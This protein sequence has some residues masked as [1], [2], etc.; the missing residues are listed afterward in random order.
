M[1]PIITVMKGSTAVVITLRVSLAIVATM[2]GS[3]CL[4]TSFSNAY[5]V[6]DLETA[7]TFAPGNGRLLA[8]AAHHTLS[9]DP[10][11]SDAQ[12]K[13]GAD[14][15]RALLTDATAAPAVATLGLLEQ[16]HGSGVAA[17]RYFAYGEWLSR[18]D[19]STQFWLIE[20]AVERGDVN[21]ALH[22]YD[23]VLRS[24]NGADDILYPLLTK[25]SNDPDISDALVR[26]LSGRPT[27]TSGFLTY[28]GD[29]SEDQLG[30]ARFFA[31]LRAKHLAVPASA[32]T[33]ILGKLVAAGRYDAA[34]D[35]YATLRQGVDRRRSRDPRFVASITSP[36]PFDWMVTADPVISVAILGGEGKGSLTF[37]VP[38][39]I[40]GE[41]VRQ[42]QLLPPGRYRLKGHSAQIDEVPSE[43]PVWSLRCVGDGREV[44]R[45]VVP[46]SSEAS[47]K[48]NAN[49][50][51]P[52]ACGAQ[53]LVLNARGSS[54]VAGL[55]GEIDFLLV[56]PQ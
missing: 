44:L 56:E 3:W 12:A 27:W 9:A 33:T 22:H 18:R 1:K 50:M 37:A 41:L 4:A 49:F 13:A 45:L 52:P 2:F 43:R 30:T 53:W 26:T 35:Y 51:V 5:A 11:S 55:I 48:F 54:S 15:R 47:G 25:A 38:P 16:L 14:A 32:Q 34:W 29:N 20:D 17:R 23:I 21:T 8:A 40:E 10:V 19:L 42:V 24:Q 28:L 7:L 46:N 31:K 39:N 6:D 36:T